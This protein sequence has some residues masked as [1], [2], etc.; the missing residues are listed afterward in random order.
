L[1]PQLE[2]GA[3][4]AQVELIP[5]SAPEFAAHIQALW[6]RPAGAA[7]APA[8]PF[9]VIAR[10]NAAQAV[11]LLG[12]RFDME[13]PQGKPYSVVHYADTLRNPQKADFAPGALRFICAEPAYTNMVLRREDEVNRRSSMNLENL[14]RARSIRASIDCVAFLDGRF[15]GPDTLGAF[16][17]LAAE[18]LA[19]SE[20]VAHFLTSELE[21]PSLAKLLEE[22]MR[23]PPSRS[24]ARQLYTDL[25][26]EGVA[27][28]SAT[29]RRHRLRIGLWR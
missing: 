10:N 26:A 29:A 1:K 3:T 9:S 13:N 11:A 20:L 25:V 6:G 8:L 12:I 4:V 19:E 24:L 23:Q 15:E 5:P 14:A 16:G 22:A 28:A 2:T 27:V 17:R 7:L 18:R 21:E